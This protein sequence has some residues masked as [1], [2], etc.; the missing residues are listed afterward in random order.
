MS[1]LVAGILFFTAPFVSAQTEAGYWEALHYTLKLESV[2]ARV[3]TLTNVSLERTELFVVTKG[4]TGKE[5]TLIATDRGFAAHG[6]SA[7]GEIDTLA[8]SEGN[9]YRVKVEKNALVV[10]R[11]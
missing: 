10:T 7:P 9:R 1:K 4:K 2:S 11:Q 6:K 5:R 3:E 8:G